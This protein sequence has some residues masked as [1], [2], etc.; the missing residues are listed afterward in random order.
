M[1]SLLTG[2]TDTNSGDGFIRTEGFQCFY[3]RSL[4]HFVAFFTVLLWSKS[5]DEL[6]KPTKSAAPERAF[7]SLIGQMRAGTYFLNWFSP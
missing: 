6:E 7:A 4:I 3:V 5:D 2:D 1:A